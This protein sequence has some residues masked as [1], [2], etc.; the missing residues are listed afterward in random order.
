MDIEKELEEFTKW[1]VNSQK[2]ISYQRY[3]NRDVAQDAWFA[4]AKKGV[5]FDEDSNTKLSEDK[6]GYNIV[7]LTNLYDLSGNVIPY[8][9]GYILDIN[10]SDNTVIIYLYGI[11]KKFLVNFTNIKIL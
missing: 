8:K 10:T 11:E 3:S 1:W 5:Q 4:R 2:G 9:L 7:L 6:I